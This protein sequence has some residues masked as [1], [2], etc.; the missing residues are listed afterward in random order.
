[1]LRWQTPTLTVTLSCL[2]M[3]NGLADTLGVAHEPPKGRTARTAAA[4]RKR[5][6]D[7]AEFLAKNGANGAVPSA[8]IVEIL[9]KGVLQGVNDPK[10][11]LRLGAA[12]SGVVT[13]FLVTP[14]T[15]RAAGSLPSAAEF[16]WLD[17]VRQMGATAVP[18]TDV[19]AGLP[20][21]T[22]YL[23]VW[24]ATKARGS[25]ARS[26]KGKFPVAVLVRPEADGT[27]AVLGWDAGAMGGIGAWTEYPRY[28]TRLPAL[29]A[30]SDRDLAD[31]DDEEAPWFDWPRTVAEKRVM[32]EE[33]LQRVLSSDQVR[34]R[35]TLLIVDAQN[36]RSFWTWV[37]D[38]QVERD[39]IR[40]GA[41][42]AGRP[43]PWLR[44]VRLRTK[45]NEET[46]QWWGL[47]PGNGVNGLP[48]DLWGSGQDDDR[49]FYS[50]TRKASTAQ[51]SAVEARK[52]MRRRLRKGARVGEWTIDVDQPAWNP[53]LVEIA[54][55]ACHPRDGDVPQALAMAVHQL[56][57]APD[58]RDALLRPLPLHLAR[59]AQEYILPMR[60]PDEEDALDPAADGLDPGADGT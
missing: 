19:P 17:A 21:R 29:A 15:S 32:T 48:A 52:L 54:V 40:T 57:Q 7:M 6:V 56:R 3:D 59:K 24:L 26:A 39:L 55:L 47:A 1:M 50:T 36:S 38:G 51:N 28:L 44:L 41:A 58:Y 4:I 35:P 46:P 18:R 34:G 42:P 49:V 14:A 33:F 5:R 9:G 16:A 12:D 8:A 31:A 13:Q 45:D 22:Q 2:R 30:V 60:E 25:T 27:D 37:Q 11:A 20:E 10:F 53:D 43:N 23:A